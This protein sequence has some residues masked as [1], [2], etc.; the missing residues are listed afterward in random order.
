MIL[1][2]RYDMELCIDI[3]LQ[4]KKTS[5]FVCIDACSIAR[6]FNVARFDCPI[7]AIYDSMFVSGDGFTPLP[8]LLIG[9]SKINFP[10][11]KS[12][13]RTVVRSFIVLC[14]RDLLSH[15]SSKHLVQCECISVSTSDFRL[16]KGILSDVSPMSLA[17]FMPLTADLRAFTPQLL[18]VPH[19]FPQTAIMS[20]LI[21]LAFVSLVVS[22]QV[23]VSTWNAPA[24]PSTVTASVSYYETDT[25]YLTYMTLTGKT[26]HNVLT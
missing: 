17:D 15:E 4:S 2:E 5:C 12:Y 26:I 10:P 3:V 25:C 11:K 22:T 7:G 1:E 16:I 9:S 14:K 13:N 8:L 24:C 18:L 19:F 23:T 20:T 6:M 21:F